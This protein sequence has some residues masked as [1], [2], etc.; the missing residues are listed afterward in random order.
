MKNQIWR[1]TRYFIINAVFV[2]ALYYGYV[3]GVDGAENLALFMGWITAILGIFV[4]LSAAA[5][6]K[7][8][9]EIVYKNN[10]LPPV[11]LWFDVI[12]DLGVAAVFAWNAHYVLAV[13]YMFSIV[14]GKEMRDAPKAVTLQTLMS[15]DKS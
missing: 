4:L 3:E 2:A 10:Y 7:K 14:A 5:D 8:F 6:R 9:A 1:T 13:L 15:G 11:P 12:F